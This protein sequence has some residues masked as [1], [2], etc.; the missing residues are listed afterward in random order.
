MHPERQASTPPPNEPP[1]QS[2]PTKLQYLA[3][4]TT[5]PTTAARTAASTPRI[6]RAISAIP[7]QAQATPTDQ[8]R[9]AGPDPWPGTVTPEQ[10]AHGEVM[11]VAL[12][13]R[14]PR[15]RRAPISNYRPSTSASRNDLDT[16]AHESHMLG[17]PRAARRAT[18]HPPQSTRKR[19]SRIPL[20]TLPHSILHV[21]YEP[22]GHPA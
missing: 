14:R 5:N 4:N 22:S 1:Q 6:A 10:D 16:R 12:P 7:T 2:A 13:D 9:E 20:R 15:Y 3:L 11:H 19:P 17:R 21:Q 18:S 8:P